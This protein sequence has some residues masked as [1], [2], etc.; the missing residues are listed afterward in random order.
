MATVIKWENKGGV[1]IQFT[2]NEYVYDPGIL[3]ETEIRPFMEFYTTMRVYSQ[4]PF[5]KSL[6]PQAYCLSYL[7]LA[8]K[9][10]TQTESFE[11]NIFSMDQD[12]LLPPYPP[13][14]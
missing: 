8:F 10:E 13:P 6:T 14:P 5:K 2:P 1:W 12:V 11:F 3:M 4:S 7:P 9:S